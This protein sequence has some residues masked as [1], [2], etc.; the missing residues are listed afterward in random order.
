MIQH[1]YKNKDAAHHAPINAHK[2]TTDANSLLR[3]FLATAMLLFFRGIPRP[4]NCS[5]FSFF[6]VVVSFWVRGR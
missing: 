2:I 1:S 3:E 6:V 4:W 5:F